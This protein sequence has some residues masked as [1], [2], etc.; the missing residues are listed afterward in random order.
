[1]RPVVPTLSAQISFCPSTAIAT[2]GR[3]EDDDP[4][5]HL[6]DRPTGDEHDPLPR[7][8]EPARVP[9]DG[10][11]TE[12]PAACGRIALDHLAPSLTHEQDEHIT[13]EPELE[14]DACG[15]DGGG[16][17]AGRGIANL[18][19]PGADE[20]LAVCPRATSTAI[21]RHRPPEPPRV[22]LRPDTGPRAV[23]R[24]A[25]SGWTGSRDRRA[26]P[27]RRTS[28]RTQPERPSRRW[29]SRPRRGRSRSPR[30]RLRSSPRPP[31]AASAALQ[32]RRR[33]RPHRPSCRRRP[34][35]RLHGHVR[36]PTSRAPDS[37][38]PAWSR[39]RDE[40][41][42]PRQEVVC[43]SGRSYPST[44]EPPVLE[45]DRRDRKARLLDRPPAD[46]GRVRRDDEHGEHGE[47]KAQPQA[48]A[49]DSLVAAA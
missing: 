25:S 18:D 24:C 5:S 15:L 23:R 1:M 2:A 49:H 27:D 3:C 33:G 46:T 44:E 7:H 45:P 10:R 17:P 20:I 28:R 8:C 29:S 31:R 48:P 42:H 40:Q 47:R 32:A 41:V 35:S 36:M 34:P 12:E 26:C 21:D 6:P 14:N 37:R 30:W 43:T 16:K 19:P 9:V 22:A 38:T 11:P 4:R 39:R 13:R